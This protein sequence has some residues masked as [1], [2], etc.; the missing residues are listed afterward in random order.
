MLR[1][2]IEDLRDPLGSYRHEPTVGSL[3]V[4]MDITNKCNL[5]CKMC[6]YPATVRQ[7]KFDMEPA[8]FRKIVDQVFCYAQTVSLACQYEPLMSR[9]F[10]DIVGEGK[11]PRVGFVT[12]GTL[13][14]RRRCERLVENPRIESIAVS[15]DGA[16]KETYEGI[17]VNAR[18]EKLVENLETLAAVKADRGTP[19]PYI[20]LNMVLMKSTVAELPLLVDFAKRVGAVVIEAIRYLPMTSGLDQAIEDWETVMPILVEAK[21][22]AYELGIYLLLPVQ[23]ERLAPYE[24]PPFESRSGDDIRGEYS[25]FCEAPWRAVQIYPD[26]SLHPC[27]YYGKAFGNLREQDFLEIWNSRPYLELRRS[28]ARLKLHPTCAACNPHGYDNIECKRDINIL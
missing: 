3:R 20:Q 6:F 28:L 5:L 26:G 19:R 9:H 22:R 10:D 23:D 4:R 21:R 15:I 27:G 17:R 12:N 8:L 18:W 7:P 1:S 14:T 11:C 25:T 16:T 24:L 13:L 2:F